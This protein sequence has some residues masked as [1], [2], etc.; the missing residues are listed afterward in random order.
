MDTD[1]EWTHSTKPEHGRMPG[2]GRANFG[3]TPEGAE[4]VVLRQASRELPR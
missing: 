2:T 4:S 3:Q 1:D